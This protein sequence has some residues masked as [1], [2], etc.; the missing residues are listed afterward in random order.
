MQNL[1]NDELF[2]FAL[3]ANK[4]ERHDTAIGY[5]KQLIENV[6]DHE[7]GLF[8]LGAEYAQ[9]G[10]FSEAIKYMEKTI[11]LGTTLTAANFQ[12]GLLYMA[13][14]E[15]DNAQESWKTI[16]QEG[17]NDYI[18][19]FSQALIHLVN[20]QEEKAKSLLAEG[21]ELNK[22]NTALNNDMKNVLNSIGKINM[23]P[24][25]QPKEKN[26]NLAEE[27]VQEEEDDNSTNQLFLSAYQTTH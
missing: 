14:E 1:S 15:Y 9:V 6:P 27:N 18:Y 4:N 25:Q 16:Q 17:E 8:L 20:N 11:E 22:D 24:F 23:F 2:H 26:V 19:I 13:T 12:L 10:L 3:D 21:I 5:L 7:Q